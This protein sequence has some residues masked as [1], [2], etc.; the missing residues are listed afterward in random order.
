MVVIPRRQRGRGAK[1]AFSFSF[2][3]LEARRTHYVDQTSFE[4]TEIH[5]LLTFQN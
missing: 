5:P 2:S 4:L 3:F 1:L